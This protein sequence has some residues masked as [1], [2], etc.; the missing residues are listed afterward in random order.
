MTQFSLTGLA[1]RIRWCL[2]DRNRNVLQQLSDQLLYRSH[3]RAPLAEV[4][5]VLVAR[6]FLTP[7][8]RI[9]AL[10]LLPTV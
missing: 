5:R 1:T 3:W 9:K 8:E 6:R 4:S 7:S 2:K 10:N